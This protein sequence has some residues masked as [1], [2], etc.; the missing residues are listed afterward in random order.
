MSRKK[1]E[2]ID[3]DGNVLSPPEPGSPV[4]QIIYLLE[5]ARARGFRIGPSVQVSDTIVQVRDLRQ[6]A[7]MTREQKQSTPDLVPGS[8][9]AVLLRGD[10]Y[11][12]DE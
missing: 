4:A 10:E 1:N 8:D 2:V 7:T 11:S 6:E 3:D 9:M 5:Y 12:G